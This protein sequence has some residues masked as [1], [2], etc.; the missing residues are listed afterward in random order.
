M[1]LFLDCLVFFLLNLNNPR[2][3]HLFDYFGSPEAERV[4]VIMGA[5]ALTVEETVEYLLEKGEKGV[6]RFFLL[7]LIHILK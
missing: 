3:Y 7:Y 5:H 1:I 6:C 2:S 4:I